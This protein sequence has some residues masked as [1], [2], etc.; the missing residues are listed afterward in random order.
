[1]L[2]ECFSLGLSRGPAESEDG[3]RQPV[4]RATEPAAVRGKASRGSRVDPRKNIP[5][6]SL[7]EATVGTKDTGLFKKNRESRSGRG[8]HVDLRDPTCQLQQSKAGPTVWG[9]VFIFPK[10]LTIKKSK[11]DT[12]H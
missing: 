2:L 6:C 8:D 1:M 4:L 9:N 7:P 3:C 5:V 10:Y 11:R 12:S